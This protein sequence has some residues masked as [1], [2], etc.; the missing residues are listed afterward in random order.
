MYIETILLILLVWKKLLRSSF[1]AHDKGVN[2]SKT[3]QVRVVHLEFPP[4]QQFHPP[5]P[6][7]GSFCD[8]L[9]AQMKQIS[10]KSFC[11]Q[12]FRATFM[13]CMAFDLF[14]ASFSCTSNTHCQYLDLSGLGMFNKTS[15][16]RYHCLIFS[17]QLNK[18]HQLVTSRER[19]KSA[20]YLR[21]KNSKRTSMCQVF[22][23]T[24]PA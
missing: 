24:V 20:P 14:A 10:L 3:S 7:S 8:Q 17:I 9:L 16:K 6:L 11:L 22:S 2:Q 23:S 19:P 13:S 21:L 15:R 18:T 12:N 1:Q 4:D 5:N